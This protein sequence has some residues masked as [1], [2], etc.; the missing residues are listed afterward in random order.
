MTVKEVYDKLS[1][2]SDEERPLYT[3]GLCQMLSPVSMQTLMEFQR[4]WDGDKAPEEFF[5]AQAEEVKK[6]VDLEISGIG[7]MVRE[8]AK[9]A[10]IS[11][12]TEV[13]I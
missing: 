8:I 11:W 12:E 9:L 5:A 6:C 1:T 3:G 2:F 10:P 13:M 7:Q 4:N